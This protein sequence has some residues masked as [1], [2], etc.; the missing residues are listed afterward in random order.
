[1]KAH[2]REL[3]QEYL[4][5]QNYLPVERPIS[6]FMAGSPG[7]G[8]TEFSKTFVQRLNAA[9]PKSPTFRL[10]PDEIRSFLPQYTGSNS[11]EM[12]AAASLG[13]SELFSYCHKK[14]LSVVID[15]TFSRPTSLENVRRAVNRDRTVVILYVYQDPLVAWKYTQQREAIEGRNIPKQAF[16]DAY[17]G[18]YQ[19]MI[20]LKELYTNSVQL[21]VIENDVINKVK[22]THIDVP[23]IRDILKINFTPMSLEKKL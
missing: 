18:A 9:S 8:K 11:Q 23:D 16:I 12:Q 21:V 22:E 6:F 13:V 20:R 15:G 14:S 5:S 7:A 2:K 10:D 1:M 19:N 3:V 17:F 4:I